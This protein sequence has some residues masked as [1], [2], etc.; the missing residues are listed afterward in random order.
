MDLA[1]TYLGL[2]LRSPI[3]PSASPLSRKLSTLQELEEAGAGAVVMYSLFEEEVTAAT[4]MFEDYLGQ[5][6][7]SHAEALSYF[8]RTPSLVYEGPDIYLEHLRRA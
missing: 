6:A 7:E 8:P 5:G 3:V 1:T 4:A 2:K